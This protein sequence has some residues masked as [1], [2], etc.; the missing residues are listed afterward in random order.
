MKVKLKKK[1]AEQDLDKFISDVYT[2]YNFNQNQKFYFDFT[3][4]EYIGNQEL[5]VFSCLLKV[6]MIS[7]VDFEVEFFPKGIFLSNLSYR[8]KRQIIEIW[9]VWK[10]YEIVPADKVFHF[11]GID[12]NSVER[13]MVETGYVPKELELYTRHGITPFIPLQFVNNYREIDVKKII[14]PLYNLNNVVKELLSAANCSHPFTSNALSSIITEELYL[15]FLDHSSKSSFQG[16]NNLAAM[17]IS[18]R[19]RLDERSY[20]DVRVQ[21]IKGFNFSTECLPESKSF[22]F[23]S[24]TKR[25]KN[26][27]FIEFSFVDFG[28]GIADSLRDTFGINSPI[29]NFAERDSDILKYAFNHD[30]S[31]HPI[32]SPIPEQK[33]I[34]RGLFDALV[35]V[36][37]YRGLMIVRS[38]KGKLLYDFSDG[39]SATEGREFLAGNEYYFPGTL[40]SIYIPAVD[41]SRGLNISTIKPEI[42]IKPNKNLAH[43]YVSFA[44]LYDNLNFDKSELYNSLIRELRKRLHKKDSPSVIFFDFATT[45]HVEKRI[46]KKVLYFLL[47]DYEINI[48][49]NVVIINFLHSHLLSEV[50]TELLELGTAI[51]NYKIHPLPITSFSPVS[52]EL[53]LVWLG[54]FDEEDRKKLQDLLY[55]EYSLASSDF[56]DPQNLAGHIIHF[57]AFGNLISNFPSSTVLIDVYRRLQDYMST[58][59]VLRIIDKYNCIWEGGEDKIFLCNG[60]YY[61]KQYVEVTDLLN[62]P[63]DSQIISR[64]LYDSIIEACGSLEDYMFIGVTTTSQKL[65]NAMEIQ[66]LIHREQYVVLDSYHALHAEDGMVKIK[67]GTKYILLCDVIAT[68]SLTQ[69]IAEK[70]KELGAELSWVGVIVNTLTDEA[71]NE[72]QFILGFKNRIKSLHRHSIAKYRI[73]DIRQELLTKQIVRINPFTNIPITLSINETYYQ[74]TVIARPKISLNAKDATIS[75]ENDFLKEV[76]EE[77]I[78]VGFLKFNNLVHPYFFN[79]DAILKRIS[80]EQLVK[81]FAKVNKPYLKQEAIKVFY[82]RKSGIESF[83]IDKLKR[84]LANHDIEQI[85]IERFN[86]PDGWR[87]P[88]NSNYIS[89]RI[90]DKI[91]FIL[92]DGSCS[93]DSLIQMVDEIAFYKV[94]EIVLLCFVGRV[95]DHKREFFSRLSGIKVREQ[96]VET[97]VYFI[98]HW[99]L[100]TYYLDENPNIQERQWINEIIS[101]PNTPIAIK[102]IARNVQTQILQRLGKTILIINI[103]LRLKVQTEK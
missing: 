95:G 4:V 17:S 76:A 97:S 37:R 74:D 28:V 23:N 66:Q 43:R 6:F 21:S 33:L 100:P 51:R 59:Q 78:K 32:T 86:T 96:S 61:Q 36:K 42:S 18:F 24:K 85:E 54:I 16:L 50:S 10:I 30:S 77:D 1:F 13:L 68:G 12:G 69:K 55:D 102:N 62:H 67:A 48:I 89:T 90:N 34:P 75:I 41:D 80:H 2:S 82:P 60:N 19:N 15:N 65:F 58:K 53:N 73:D 14:N 8:V 44:E 3:E 25:Y 56:K 103:C 9:I 83:D 45:H 5:L 93:G 52:G 88:H 64:L 29:Q 39:S 27:P 26:I 31:R 94:K 49:N 72:N 98:S 38:N 92:D 46:L 81:V 57:D 99:H 101:L 71:I 63:T 91:C 40:V 22:F 7:G 87:F 70:L 47:S 35:L 79:T 11:F 84:V 20:E